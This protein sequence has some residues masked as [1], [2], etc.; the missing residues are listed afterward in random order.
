MVNKQLFQIG[1]KPSNQ[2]I[3]DQLTIQ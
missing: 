1:L 2:L 3:E